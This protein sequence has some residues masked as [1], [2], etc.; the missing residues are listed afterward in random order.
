MK[1]SKLLASLVA[2]PT[3]AQAHPGHDGHELTWDFSASSPLLIASGI[4]TTLLLVATAITAR[5]TR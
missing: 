1:T 4:V 3:L 2:V 5:R